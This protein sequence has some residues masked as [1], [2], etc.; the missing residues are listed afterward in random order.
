MRQLFKGDKY[1]REETIRGNTVYLFVKVLG[2]PARPPWDFTQAMT[3]NLFFVFVFCKN[4]LIEFHYIWIWFW[5]S[6]LFE[7]C[8]FKN[9][10]L[11]L[12]CAPYKWTMHVRMKHP[13][14]H[15]CLHAFICDSFSR[16]PCSILDNMYN[17]IAF[18]ID[19]CA[20]WPEFSNFV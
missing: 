2:Q 11:D 10:N 20:L 16:E 7:L 12:Q 13:G 3:M 5:V 1:S 18:N 19:I 9:D 15:L 4:N 17:I 6:K 14:S 8:I